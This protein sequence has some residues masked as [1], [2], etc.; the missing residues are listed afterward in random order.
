MLICIMADDVITQPH[1]V[2]G[3]RLLAVMFIKYLFDL[4]FSFC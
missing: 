1:A 3:L 2:V 4:D